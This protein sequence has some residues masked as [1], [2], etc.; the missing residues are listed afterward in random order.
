MKVFGE[1]IRNA[2]KYRALSQRELSV[3]SGISRSSISMIE[4]SKIDIYF[5]TAKR[6]AKSLDI[7]LPQFFSRNFSNGKTA[8]YI[9]DNFLLIFSQNVTSLLKKKNKYQT[10][11]YASTN[12]SPS[13]INE[14]L[15]QKVNPKLSSLYQIADALETTVSELITRKGE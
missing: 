2:R 6:L 3:K 13:T 7:S 12:L 1:N 9:E 5:E 10:Y 14:I 15:K 4:N 8:T 11:L